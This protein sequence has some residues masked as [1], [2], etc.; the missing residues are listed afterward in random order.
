MIQ[1]TYLGMVT[2]ITICW[3]VGR[4]I[5]AGVKRSVDLKHELKLLT[6]YI[7]I[8]VISRFVYFPMKLEDGHVAPIVF[9]IHRAYPFRCSFEPFLFLEQR[10]YGYQLNVIGNVAMFVPLGIAL[11]F[12]FNKLNNPIKVTLVGFCYTVFIEISQ[13]PLYQRCTDIDDVILNTT[14]VIIGSVAYFLVKAIF[15]FSAS[16]NKDSKKAVTLN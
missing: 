16:D 5:N 15:S 13:L 11:P 10:Y 14:G 2:F 9:D 8:V 12:C 4:L 3:I 7:C 1:I 6:I